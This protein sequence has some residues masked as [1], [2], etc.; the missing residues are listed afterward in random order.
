MDIQRF[1]RDSFKL[2]EHRLELDITIP[3]TL[4]TRYILNPNYA[5]TG[6]QVISIWIYSICGRGYMVI[7]HSSSAQKNGKLKICIDFK[8]RNVA[9]K[10]DPY[11]LPFPNEVL[12]IVAR[13]FLNGYSGYHQISITQKDIYKIA[14]VID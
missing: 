8:K 13:Y 14:F 12:N 7:T 2:A 11:P 4:Q 3:S 1:E 9:T 6:K 10:K 5:T